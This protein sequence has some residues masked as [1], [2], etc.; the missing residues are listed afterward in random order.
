MFPYVLVAFGPTT[1]DGQGGAYR[2]TC[3]DAQDELHVSVPLGDTDIGTLYGAAIDTDPQDF[4]IAAHAVLGTWYDELP[5]AC[6]TGMRNAT[7]QL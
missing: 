2:Y 1:F 7:A 5:P 6:K 4:A 3:L